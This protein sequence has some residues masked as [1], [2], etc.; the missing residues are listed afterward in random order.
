MSMRKPK[1]SELFMVSVL[2]ILTVIALV[3]I[4]NVVQNPELPSESI[5][6][7]IV[8]D[9]KDSYNRETCRLA[10]IKNKTVDYSYQ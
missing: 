3:A 8:C 10:E 9:Q 4:F 6:Y 2:T 1:Y 7:I 5:E